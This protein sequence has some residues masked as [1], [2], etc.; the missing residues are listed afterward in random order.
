MVRV[1]VAHSHAHNIAIY[2]CSSFKMHLDVPALGSLPEPSHPS[3]SAHDTLCSMPVVCF[4]SLCHPSHKV[5][6][7]SELCLVYSGHMEA[8]QHVL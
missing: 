6:Q 3:L 5:L 8:V 2:S 7:K 4:L 1:T